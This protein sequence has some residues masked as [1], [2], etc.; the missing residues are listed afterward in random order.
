MKTTKKALLAL[1][2][3]AALVFGSV[4]ATYAYLTS[5]T[6]TVT[7]TFTVGNVTITLD[8]A[9]VD[10]SKTNVT[11]EGR[12]M[13]N[14]YKLVPGVTYAKDPTVHIVKGSEECYVF[15]KVTNGLGQYEAADGSIKV[16]KSVY[17]NIAKQMDEKGWKQ[18]NGVSGVY[19]LNEKVNAV[20]SKVDI[21]K[22]VFTEFMVANTVN[23][24]TNVKDIVVEAY[25]VQAAGFET[26]AK[27]WEAAPLEA[28]TKQ[29]NA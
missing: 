15:V 14:T 25:A 29:A 7:N 2:C 23:K 22:V 11:T 17:K 18:L 9:D 27:A 4:F 28:W 21:D 6:D 10:G 19:Y 16:D 13:K 26:A 1:V 12:D 5:T 24:D 20:E 8:E 3:A